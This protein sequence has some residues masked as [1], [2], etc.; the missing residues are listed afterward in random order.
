MGPFSDPYVKMIQL[1]GRRRVKTRRTTMK[2]A[3]LHPVY[4]ETLVFDLPESQI[5]NTNILIKVM[6]W[7]R[8]VLNTVP[9]YDPLT[10]DL[11][12]QEQP[13]RP[14]SPCSYS[15]RIG[16]DDLLGCSVLGS[17]SPTAEGRE[18]WR[19]CFLRQG[20]KPVGMWHSLLAEV[21]EGFTNITK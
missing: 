21:P 4:N 20:D 9:T 12:T 3:N 2:R 18:H 16:H 14:I 10:F 13:T 6:D 15:F 1:Q 7:D 8:Y 11:A 17:E 19:Q 5:G